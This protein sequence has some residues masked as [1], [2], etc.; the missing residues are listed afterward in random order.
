[1]CGTSANSNGVVITAA[2][3]PTTPVVTPTGP[4]DLC[5]NQSQLLTVSNPCTGCTFD[6]SNSATGST[7]TVNTA[8]TYTATATNS[9]GTSAASNGVVINVTQQP[10]NPTSITASPSGICLGNSSTLTVN[11][12]LTTGATWRWYTGSCGGT[13]YGTGPS[14]TVNPTVSTTYYV[15]AENGIC[16]S[17][18]VQQTITVL[19][20]PTANAGNNVSIC[21]GSS[22]QIGTPGVG[23][24]T[25]QWSPGFG[26]SNPNIAMP[27]A[28]PFNTTTYT[29]IATNSSG[30]S[31]TD[32]VVVTVNALPNANA[33][34][35][36][37]TC[38]GY[39]VT[40][41]TTMVT[42]YNYDWLP[43]TALNSTVVA[44]PNASPTVAT[45]YT[46]TV[47]N[48]GTGCVDNDIVV[49]NVYSLPTADA[50]ADVTV[51]YQQPVT[52][53]GTPT[54]TGNGPFTYSWSP[55]F[56]LNN[57]NAANPICTP[58]T[59][60][61]Y[62]VTI[63]DANGCI[64]VDTIV[65]TVIQPCTPP[66][67]AFTASALMANCPATINFTD[68]SQTSGATSWQWTIWV[69]GGAPMTY[70]NQNPAGVQYLV[71]GTFA[72]QL[73]V[74]D[75]CSSDTLLI[76]NYITIICPT[77]VNSANIDRTIKVY[78]NPA[79]DAVNITA[80][81]VDNGDYE[82]IVQNVLGQTIYTQSFTV[83][84]NMMKEQVSLAPYANGVYMLQVKGNGLNMSKKI[85]KR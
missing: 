24:T 46:L 42:G 56:Y 25:Y 64:D 6:W 65:V 11:G 54:G 39:P 84:N 40:I 5:S 85:E 49:V 71:Q 76:P 1:M 59:T 69:N 2:P 10:N 66:T 70:T 34:P 83:K 33:G 23:G 35:N 41:G 80:D 72:A 62:T 63:T 29:L 68:Q 9:C 47:T 15:R 60:T 28:F 19:S 3:L 13:L 20:V 55:V 43:A 82:L 57:A 12:T 81:Y 22:A 73:I 75:T 18:C 38:S 21:S 31:D 37:T 48:P 77:S 36:V 53:G 74:T 79:T 52:I 67:A 51:G 27:N 16:V 8:G 32:Q 78:P 58:D 30:C 45:T 17:S 14:I 4:V 7:T 50:G 44:M 61:T 26:L